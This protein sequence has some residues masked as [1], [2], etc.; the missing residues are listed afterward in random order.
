MRS[1]TQPAVRKHLA[2]LRDAR[3]PD[4]EHVTVG[5]LVEAPE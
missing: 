3:L 5:A 4:A 1:G 2:D